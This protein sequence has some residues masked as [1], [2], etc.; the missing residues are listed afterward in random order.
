MEFC[1]VDFARCWNSYA[2]KNPDFL[3]CAV[4]AARLENGA[5][6]L[7]DTSYS[8]PNQVFSMPTYW[9]FKFWGEK[10]MLTFSIGEPKLTIFENGKE[11]PTFYTFDEKENL[12]WLEDFKN[13]INNNTFDFTK[14][15]IDSSRA[16]LKI[17]EASK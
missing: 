6:V 11:E 14:S 13:E 10:G 3:D 8:G 17:Q 5:E 15:V 7:A 9:N 2:Y 1:K 4:F 16:V 12:A